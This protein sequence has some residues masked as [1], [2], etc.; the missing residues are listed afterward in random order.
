MWIYRELTLR[1]YRGWRVRYVDGEEVDGWKDGPLFR[2]ELARLGHEGWE[3]AGIAS[4]GRNE[5]AVYFK[6]PA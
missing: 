6:R 3:M 5:R 4:S 2:D 1:D